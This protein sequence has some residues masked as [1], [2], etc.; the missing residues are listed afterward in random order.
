MVFVEESLQI[1]LQEDP[2]IKENAAFVK[3]KR[4]LRKSNKQSAREIIVV[5]FSSQ[6]EVRTERFDLG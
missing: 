6:G 3:G 1:Y 4:K 5:K 2:L